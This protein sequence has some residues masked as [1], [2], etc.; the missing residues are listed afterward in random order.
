MAASTNPYAAAM[1]AQAGATSG[2]PSAPVQASRLG[3]ENWSEAQAVWVMRFG[4]IINGALMAATAIGSFFLASVNQT[5]TAARIV[6]S[7]YLT[8]GARSAGGD[9]ARGLTAP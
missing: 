6:L 8:C 7:S 4:N 1:A 9:C 2:A 5:S 3:V